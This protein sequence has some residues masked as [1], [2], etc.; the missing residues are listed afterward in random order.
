[1]TDRPL[2]SGAQKSMARFFIALGTALAKEPQPAIDIHTERASHLP[3]TP[4]DQADYLVAARESVAAAYAWLY[5]PHHSYV[6]GARDLTWDMME[7]KSPE[8]GANALLH[9]AIT[10]ASFI[11]PGPKE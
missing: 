11:V 6:E 10:G 8:D 2:A 7:F 5:G 3:K 1:M 4:Q 9:S